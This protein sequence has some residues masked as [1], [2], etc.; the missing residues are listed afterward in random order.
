[1]G[2]HDVKYRVLTYGDER[3]RRK[4]R[5]VEQVDDGIRRLAKDLLRAMYEHNG[6]G[7]A[8][9]QVGR[10]EA[11]CVI[12][13]STFTD[14][15]TGEPVPPNPDIPMPLIMV[16]PALESTRGE[17]IASEGCLSFPEIYVKIKR[18]EEVK[19]AYTDLEN[20]RQ[21][22]QASGLLA[23]AMQHELDH[24][25]GVLLVDRMSAV[26]RVSVAGKLKRL[27]KEAAE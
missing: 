2:K 10:D 4:A 22:A 8:A 7:L 24:L 19:M 17:Q 14:T 15:S 18:A 23:R 9:S 21:V 13:M 27:K 3:L 1:M 25:N 11:V 16:N 5:P 20:R 12:D 6:L 26:Q